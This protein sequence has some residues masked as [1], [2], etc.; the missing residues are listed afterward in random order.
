MKKFLVVSFMLIILSVTC[1]L[2]ATK[3]NDSVLSLRVSPE[4][5][6]R[7]TTIYVDS[8]ENIDAT[9]VVMDKNDVIVKVIYQGQLKNGETQ[10]T[11]DGTDY[12]GSRLPAEKYQIELTTGAKY[13]SLKKII[14]LK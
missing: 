1:V 3:V 8:Q 13:T 12:K 2:M 6:I 14:I 7:T 11:W 9:L 10:F 5:F 4:E